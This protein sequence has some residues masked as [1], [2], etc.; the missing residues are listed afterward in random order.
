M[1]QHIAESSF[2]K[3]QE[4]KQATFFGKK[5][6]WQ[7]SIGKLG[8]GIEWVQNYAK[9]ALRDVPYAPAAMACT[10][11]LLPLLTSPY[12]TDGENNTGFLYVS[13]QIRY[14]IA[15][16]TCLPSDIRHDD[17]TAKLKEQLKGL[18]KLVIDYQVQSVMK[19]NRNAGKNFLR[20]VVDYDDWSG[21]LKI[22]Q[23]EEKT[24]DRNFHQAAAV[25]KLQDFRL[26]LQH[27][28]DLKQEAQESREQLQDIASYAQKIEQHMYESEKRRVLGTLKATDPSLE[29]QSLEKRKGGLLEKSYGWVIDNEDFKR[30]KNASSGQLLWVKGDPGKGKTMLLCGIINE[31]SPV[32]TGDPNI[33]FFFCRA[34][35]ESLNTFS[36]VLRGLIFMLVEQQPSL[37]NHFQNSFDGH[38]S[39]VALVETLA[40][41]LNDPTLHPTYFV[42]DGLDE[43]IE[44]RQF[45][46]DLIVEHSS[47]HEKVKWIVSSRNWVEIEL[48]LGRVTK[49]TLQLELNEVT[50]S[51]AVHFFIDYKVKKLADAI[52]R[53][54]EVWKD[55]KDHLLQNANDTFL[56][57]A[58]VCEELAKASRLGSVMEKLGEFPPGLENIYKRMMSQISEINSSSDP[59]T[60][61]SILGLVTT[62]LRPITLEEMM[63][64]IEV[65]GDV[66]DAL[67]L[68]RLCGSF[69]SVQDGTI[70]LIHQS[71][72]DFLTKDETSS[73]IYPDGK[74]RVH[75]DLFSKSLQLIGRT[76][77]SDVYGLS[78]PGYPIEQVQ[79][80]NPDPL[81]AVR[82]ACVYWVDHII[83]SR[84][85]DTERALQ[86]GESVYSFLCQSYLCWLEAMSILKSI[87]GAIAS[88]QKLEKLIEVCI[89]QA[90]LRI[91]F[92][93][94]IDIEMDI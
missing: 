31:L 94:D 56:W 18:Y 45:L 76:L 54:P 53:K 72:K 21:L 59:E 63:V 80:P 25:L 90:G 65:R 35:E 89:Y 37:T 78:A 87:P 66:N 73:K 77:R 32:L 82:Y 12:K 52:P 44:D 40:R 91:M 43:C 51:K 64:Y 48:S 22:I 83:C 10:S 36:A 49:M 74:E 19:F 92:H 42:I 55:V 13:S 23:E 2:K 79:P 41:I 62:V 3:M 93:T 57:V 71:A 81:L 67:D 46:L 61:L 8:M 4:G 75:Y 28:R 86:G 26:N 84:I 17:I 68:V 47:A 30:W 85:D 5:I 38:N 88:L 7:E 9:D 33:A 60:C 16:E 6:V 39:W 69:L 34:S 11:L 70:F 58:L 29:K 15:M 1:L 20:S 14:Y 24:L 50:L 27:L